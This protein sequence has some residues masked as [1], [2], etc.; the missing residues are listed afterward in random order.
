MINKKIYL[1]N[2]YIPSDED[3]VVMSIWGLIKTKNKIYWVDFIRNSMLGGLTN[4]PGC[5]TTEEALIR[6]HGFTG[7]V[8]EFVHTENFEDVIRVYN[9]IKQRLS[10]ELKQT[11]ND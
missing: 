11:T 4:N 3:V 1:V 8:W 2:G 5:E 10:L 9:E 6:I 7:P